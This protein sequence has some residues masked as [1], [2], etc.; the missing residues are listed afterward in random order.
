MRRLVLIGSL[1]IVLVLL[2]AGWSLNR[3]GVF[4]VFQDDTSIQIIQVQDIPQ[5]LNMKA[6]L[7]L[8][9]WEIEKAEARDDHFTSPTC[10]IYFSNGIKL[11]LSISPNRYSGMEQNTQIGKYIYIVFSKDERKVYQFSQGRLQY[12]F[13]THSA[14]QEEELKKYLERVNWS[15]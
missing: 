12:N 5:A 14:K 10:T 15:A 8:P 9:D 11:L 4:R 7:K 2:A 6:S 1:L 13:Q 3:M